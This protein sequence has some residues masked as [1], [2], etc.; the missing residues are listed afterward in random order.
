MTT[1]TCAAAARAAAPNEIP[2]ILLKLIDDCADMHRT[3]P[4]ERPIHADALARHYE[5]APSC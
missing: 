4:I 3:A 2:T 1:D 5:G